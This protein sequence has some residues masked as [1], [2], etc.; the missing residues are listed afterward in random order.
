M[1]VKMTQEEQM[2]LK[3]G[4]LEFVHSTIAENEGPSDDGVK[5]D[6]FFILPQILEF[7]FKN[8]TV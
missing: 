7:M 5:R 2:R 3:K 4:L 6:K 1:T 8:F